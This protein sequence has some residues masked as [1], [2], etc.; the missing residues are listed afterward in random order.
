VVPLLLTVTMSAT[1]SQVCEPLPYAPAYS[2]CSNGQA[3]ALI[4]ALGNTNFDPFSLLTTQ[5]NQS[6]EFSG[7]LALSLSVCPRSG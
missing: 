1:A 5:P 4:T 6:V 2:D 3:G 7:Q